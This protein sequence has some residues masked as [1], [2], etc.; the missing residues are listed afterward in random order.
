MHKRGTFVVKNGIWKGKGLELEAK[1]LRLN[2]CWLPPPGGV[3]G[4]QKALPSVC[5]NLR[6][7]IIYFFIENLSEFL[8]T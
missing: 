6:R 7:Y 4:G 1:P 2:I 3:K 5:D 8:F